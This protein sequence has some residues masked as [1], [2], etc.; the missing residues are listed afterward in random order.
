MASE[1]DKVMGEAMKNFTDTLPEAEKLLL[2]RGMSTD[3]YEAL[4]MRTEA[5]Q[6]K[7]LHRLVQ[8]GPDAMRLDNAARGLAGDAGEVSSAVMKYIEYGRDLDRVNLVEEVGD[9]LWRL[10]Q[11][12]KAAGFTLNQAMQ[13]NINKLRSRYPDRYSDERSANRN[14]EAE[15][16]A[17]K[18]HVGKEEPVVTLPPEEGKRV[19]MEPVINQDGHGFGHVDFAPNP[20]KCTV[21]GGEHDWEL[22]QTIPGSGYVCRKC[23]VVG[24]V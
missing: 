19:R 11:V 8:L 21:T 24:A 18:E 12:C 20:P 23:G 2:P 5:D 17:V 7:I 14:P 15:R 13:A 3:E 4:A 6:R 10:A 22:I 16:A 9:C 1:L